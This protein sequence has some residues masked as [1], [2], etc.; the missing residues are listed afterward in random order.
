MNYN[1]IVKTLCAVLDVGDDIKIKFVDVL[2]SP[3]QLG[4][5]DISKRIIYLKKSVVSPFDHIFTIAHELRHFWQGAGGKYVGR[6]VPVWLR[7]SEEYNAQQSEI[8][9]N[10]FAY[11]YMLRVYRVEPKNSVLSAELRADTRRRMIELMAEYDA[12]LDAVSVI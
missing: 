9:A 7:A 3:T 10:A 11:W 12:K 2:T 5:A 1:D 8:D 4:A 6:G